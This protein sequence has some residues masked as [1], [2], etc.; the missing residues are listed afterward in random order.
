MQAVSNLHSINPDA[1]AE[2]AAEFDPTK[3]WVVVPAYNEDAVIE[4][5]VAGLSSAGFS[6][7]VV[8]DGSKQPL[9]ERLQKANCH[10]LRH[11]INLGQGAALQTGIDYALRSGATAIATFDADGQH[12][13]EDLASLAAPVFNNKC[14]V[15]LGSRF[16]PGGSAQNAPKSRLALLRLATRFSR[17]S[18]GLPITDTHNGL[19]VFSRSA[20]ARIQ[21][22]QNRM[23]HASQLLSQIQQENLSIQEVPVTIRYTPYSLAKGQRMSN[24]FN[25]VW[26]S[27][28][29]IFQ[30]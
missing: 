13:V 22:T 8:D 21:I 18:S 4:E 14:E 7:V 30:R 5:V 12:S 25:I 29:E 19:R 17:F 27:F 11:V 20:A 6:V 1:S 10:I 26:E 2:G 3:L 23:A 9:D 15:A 16:L 24:I 28:T